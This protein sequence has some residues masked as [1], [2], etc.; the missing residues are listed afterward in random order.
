MSTA[1]PPSGLPATVNSAV[2]AA[3]AHAVVTTES[4]EN[5]PAADHGA[6]RLSDVADVINGAENTRLA[7]WTNTVPAVILNIQRQ[8]GSNVI[9]RET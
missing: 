9:A 6:V 2:A 4:Q 5:G 3:A 8:P 7:A 1:P